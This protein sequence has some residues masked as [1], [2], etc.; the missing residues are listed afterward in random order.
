VKSKSI[1]KCMLLALVIMVFGLAWTPNIIA[2]ELSCSASNNV[3]VIPSPTTVHSGDEIVWSISIENICTTNYGSFDEVPAKLV[4]DGSDVFHPPLELT[5]AV[6][7]PGTFTFINCT[8]LAAGMDHCELKAS[9]PN[10]VLLYTTAGGVSFNAGETIAIAKV[11]ATAVTPVSNSSH[12]AVTNI[13]GAYDFANAIGVFETTG[14]QCSPQVD[15]GAQGTTVEFFPPQPQPC[16]DVNKSVEPLKSKAGDSV[17]YTVELCNCGAVDLNSITVSDNKLGNLVPPFP[18]AL[19]AGTVSDSTIIP[20][21]VTHTISWTIPSNTTEDP[22]T[23][24]VTATGIPAGQAQAISDV[25]Q[26]SVDLFQPCINIIKDCGP[27]E[28]DIGTPV[29]YKI[30]LNNCSSPD[31]PNLN[32]SINDTL[33]QLFPKNVPNF[34]SGGQDITNET[35]NYQESDPDT[36]TN[37]ASVTCTIPG[38]PNVLNATYS[39]SVKKTP[40]KPCIDIKKQISVN[41]IFFKKEENHCGCDESKEDYCSKN[42]DDDRYC[43]S[44]LSKE[45]FCGERDYEKTHCGCNESKEDY[46]ENYGHYDDYCKDENECKE[47]FCKTLCTP[48]WLDADIE[49][50]AA[51]L[52]VRDCDENEHCDY[53][54]DGKCDYHDKD[55]CDS[56]HY[57]CDKYD[58]D[59]CDYDHDGKCDYHDVEICDSNYDGKCDYHDKETCDS[60]K[61]GAMYRIIVTNCGTVDLTDVVITD[62]TLLGQNSYTI[63]NLAA[64]DSVILTSKEIPALQTAEQC[65]EPG[66]IVNTATATGTNSSTVT[67]SDSA[68]LIC[69]CLTNDDCKDNDV[70]TIDTC[71][72]NQCVYTPKPDCCTCYSDC[73]DNNACT[74]DK[75]VYGQC[76]HTQKRCNDYNACTIDS[77]DPVKGCI[78]TPKPDCCTCNSDCNDNNACTIDKCAYGQCT[79]TQKTCNDY[80]ACTIDSCDPVK[81]CIHTRKPDCCTCSSD[82]NGGKSYGDLYCNQSSHTCRRRHY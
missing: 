41:C 56:H 47:D 7:R 20:N 26:A 68:W 60:I 27:Q 58:Y 29:S 64:G 9:D 37:T 36:L 59:H 5:M 81:G 16:I 2:Q 10:I 12:V 51:V 67:D 71:V 15:S 34:P 35:R 57:R 3:I 14:N 63:G 82:C 30:T 40:S 48:E 44:N 49:A 25:A 18:T 1:I 54:Y 23:N 53:N 13:V 55:Y 24:T 17:T 61:K 19:A 78:H 75:C 33:L 11:H 80:N 66:E 52:N 62:P 6:G 32:C 39:C 31:T 74:I 50:T 79:H 77:C 22:Y 42:G 28:V 46:C 38:F 69:G 72:N 45:E 43:G 70:C 21:C 65:C 8:D 73:N 4:A 76:I